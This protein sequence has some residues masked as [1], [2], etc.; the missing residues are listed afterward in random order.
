MQSHINDGQTPSCSHLCRRYY[1]SCST[2]GMSGIAVKDSG[3]AVIVNKAVSH[4]RRQDGSS[5]VYSM[6]YTISSKKSILSGPNVCTEMAIFSLTTVPSAGST[7]WYWSPVTCSS[8]K[9]ST[10]SNEKI[11]HTNMQVATWLTLSKHDYW[12]RS[13]TGRSSEKTNMLLLYLHSPLKH[14]AYKNI[15]YASFWFF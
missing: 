13:R 2:P 8:F 1:T 11:V 9:T 4:S 14:A 3:D 10:R 6:D 7:W 15:F 5:I 12:I